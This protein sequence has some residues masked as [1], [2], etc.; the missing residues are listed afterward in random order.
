MPKHDDFMDIT[1]ILNNYS[2]NIYNDMQISSKKIA[3]KGVNTLKQTSP[4]RTGKYSKGWSVKVE[5]NGYNFSSTI[6][7]ATHW[8][9]THLLEKPHAKRNG[10]MTKPK[11][12]IAP[13]EKQCI[14]EYKKDVVNIIK[15]G[16]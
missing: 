9:L 4:K 7:N 6:Y 5:D 1:T 10:Q 3:D 13:V 14:D 15:K 8:R 2:K 11:K 12:H 16:A